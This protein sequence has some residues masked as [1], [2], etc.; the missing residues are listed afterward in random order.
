MITM[1]MPLMVVVVFSSRQI[2]PQPQSGP[3]PQA[4]L[5]ALGTDWPC[6]FQNLGGLDWVKELLADCLAAQLTMNSSAMK[7]LIAL[8]QQQG[9]EFSPSKGQAHVPV[10]ASK[11]SPNQHS[12]PRK[13]VDQESTICIDDSDDEVM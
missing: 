2:V 12:E 9:K 13:G 8:R 6:K 10:G 5:Q 11:Q 1:M 4:S 7:K 3:G